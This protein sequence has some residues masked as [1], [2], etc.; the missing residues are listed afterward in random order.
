[1]TVQ[2]AGTDAGRC[3]GG[4]EPSPAV[5]AGTVAENIAYGRTATQE[6]IEAAARVANA[7]EFISAM[8]NGYMVTLA[9][10]SLGD[11]SDVP[12]ATMQSQ[13]GDEGSK[14]SG[15]QRQRIAIARAVLKNPRVLLLDEV[16]CVL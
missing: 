1:L 13:V 6:A 12:R 15:G 5:F 11:R 16:R 8:D 3:V 7:H 14:L 10:C 2:P 9:S 4:A